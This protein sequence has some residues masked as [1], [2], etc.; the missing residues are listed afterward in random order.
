MNAKIHV[1]R[2]VQDHPTAI[3]VDALG[4]SVDQYLQAAAATAGRAV[5]YDDMSPGQKAAYTKRMQ[6]KQVDWAESEQFVRRRDVIVRR[7]IEDLD[8]LIEEGV[9]R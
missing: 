1:R 5:G 8:Q 4:A 7:L 2:T 9:V 6:A 3:F